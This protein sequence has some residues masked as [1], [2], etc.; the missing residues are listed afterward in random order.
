MHSNAALN[1]YPWGWT[2]TASP[3]GPDLANIGAH[4][5]AANASGNGYQSCQPPACLYSVDGDSFD[6][7]YG[8]LGVASFTTEVGGSSF[9]PAYSTLDAMFTLN[10]GALLYQTKIVRTPYLTTRGPDANNVAATPMTVTIGTSSQLTGTINYAWTGNAYAQNVAA[11]E[12]YVDTPPWAG[13][14]AIAMSPTDGSFNSQTEA[15]NATV[16]TGALTV[17]RHILFVRGRGV[18]SYSGLES[19]GTVS[20]AFLDVLPPA[21]PTSTPTATVTGTPPTATITSTPTRTPTNTNTLVPTNTFTATPTVCTNYTFTSSTGNAIVAGTTDIGNH[22]DDLATTITLPFAYSLYGQA[23]TGASASSNGTL[24]FTGSTTAFTNACLPTTTLNNTILAHWDDLRTDAQTNCSA[25]ASGCGIFT[26]TSGSA[27]NRIFNIEWRAVLFTGATVVNFEI[28]LYEGQSRFD[29]VYGTVNGSGGSATVGV[30]RDTGSQFV[31]FSCNTAS[32]SSG[33]QIVFTLPACGTPLPTNTPTRTFTPGVAT[34]TRTNTPVNTA[35]ATATCPPT[36]DNVDIVD[37]DYSPQNLTVNVGTTVTWTNNGSVGHTATSDS[38]AWDSGIIPV[39]G[40]FVFTFNSVGTFAYHCTIHPTIMTGT[41]T[42]V[43]GCASTS[44]PTPRP[45]DTPSSTPTPAFP[46]DAFVYFADPSGPITNTNPVTITQGVSVTINLRV[47]SG[48]SAITAAQSYLTF[49]SSLLQMVNVVQPGCVLTSTMTG[50]TSV[51]DAVLQN[52]TCNG[53]SP[54]VFRGIST[55]PGSIAFASGALGNPAARGDF[56]VAQFALCAMAPGDAL[57]HW[58]FSPPAPLTRDSEVVDDGG[59]I[60]SDPR[61]Y[62]DLRIHI[63]PQVTQLRGHV[64]IQGRPAQPNALQ[65]V[66][67]TFTLKSGSTETNYATTT[68]ASG[69]F[70][71]TAPT[72]GVYNWRVKHAQTLA[73][74]GS[75][76]LTNGATTNQEM[77]LLQMGDCNNDNCVNVQDFS[78]LKNSFGKT[79]GD[80]GYDPRADFNGDNAVTVVDFNVQKSNFGICGAPPISP[81]L[82]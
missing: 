8:Q 62:N 57:L 16:T 52:E 26:S 61:L 47:V 46:R 5:S 21:G 65:S 24:Q 33:L 64:T 36:S 78:L 71:V 43:P 69:Y 59:N 9:F 2:T 72:G 58:E 66:P 81:I 17:G 67:I 18:N 31:Q 30:Q 44:T 1:L 12:Y 50:D 6:W 23:F 68:D 19:W 75:V 76:T 4:M 54:C 60:V 48:S 22:A 49:T 37:F 13:G 56:R 32:L 45:S 73:N 80:P 11:A 74:S 25:F 70:T 27:P 53:P 7:S 40:R 34:N 35:T 28:R 15:V 63:V 41:I 14:T 51:F 38:A 42:V 77:G 79:Q 3:N 39:G 29:L 10:R 20:A 82:K 55:S